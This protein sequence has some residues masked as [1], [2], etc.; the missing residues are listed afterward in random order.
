M[1]TPQ[2]KA[3]W[4]AL[5]MA[6][7]LGY[8]ITIPLVL[9]ALAG[10]WADSQ[11]HTKPWLFLGGVIFAIVSTSLLLVRKFSRIVRDLNPVRTPD[12]ISTQDIKIPTSKDNR[13]N[14]VNTPK[15]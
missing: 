14:G 10:R 5:N 4:Q 12:E 6:W 3:L 13:S 9:F 2:R 8:T 15:S 11:F 7:E 1:D